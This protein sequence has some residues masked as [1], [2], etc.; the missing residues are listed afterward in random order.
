MPGDYEVGHG[1][2]PKGTRFRKGQSGNPKGRPKG[3]RNISTDAKEMLNQKVPIV[4]DGKRKKVTVQLANLMRLMEKALSGDI[5]A[6]TQVQALAERFNDD[7]D[8]VATG[9]I[10]EPDQEILK[11]FLDKNSTPRMPD[12]ADADA[13]KSVADQ[14]QDDDA[15]LR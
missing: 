9:H 7:P 3:S 2:P 15:W 4:V 14:E 11:R 10:S 1:R 8:P 6:M 13:A 12:S 5:K